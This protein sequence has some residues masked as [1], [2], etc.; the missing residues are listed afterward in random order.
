MFGKI[1]ACGCT[2]AL[3]Q[4]L[5]LYPVVLIKIDKNMNPIRDKKGFCIACKPGE[6]GLLIG[7][8]GNTPLNAYSG[9]ANDT[10]GCRKKILENVFKRSQIAINSSDLMVCDSLGYIYFCD[11]LGETYR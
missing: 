11:R 10:S 1:G 9:Y 2:P 5:K 8:I 6:K 4:Y 7:L 3:N